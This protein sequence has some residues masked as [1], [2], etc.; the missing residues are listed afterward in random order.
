MHRVVC[1][2]LETTNH[3]LGFAKA[4]EMI[5]NTLVH[6]NVSEAGMYIQRCKDLCPRTAV[7]YSA[8]Y[9]ITDFFR[10]LMVWLCSWFGSHPLHKQRVAEFV[11]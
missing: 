11:D 4:F 3:S 5:R 2:Y 10:N 1:S 7:I 6:R 9:H 8:T